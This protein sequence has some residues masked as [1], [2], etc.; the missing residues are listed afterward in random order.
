MTVS[1]ALARPTRKDTLKRSTRARPTLFGEGSRLAQGLGDEELN[2][3]VEDIVN[4]EATVC[5][6]GGGKAYERSGHFVLSA[7]LIAT[8]NIFRH[9]RIA[10]R[11]ELLK[12]TEIATERLQ[13][14]LRCK[15]GRPIALSLIKIPVVYCP[16]HIPRVQIASPAKHQDDLHNTYDTEM[17][18]EC[19]RTEITQRRR[20]SF[21]RVVV[22]QHLTESYDKKNTFIWVVVEHERA[23]LEIDSRNITFA[24]FRPRLGYVQVYDHDRDRSNDQ[25]QINVLSKALVQIPQPCSYRPPNRAHKLARFEISSVLLLA[26]NWD[27]ADGLHRKDG[28]NLQW[29]ARSR[30]PVDWNGVIGLVARA[31]C[32]VRRR[33]PSRS[34]GVGITCSLRTRNSSSSS[35]APWYGKREGE[36]NTITCGQLERKDHGRRLGREG[37]CVDTS[38]D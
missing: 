34:I 21:Q 13:T 29:S 7:H 17:K 2:L 27:P 1:L 20:E 14:R 15:R 10:K 19:G 6:G 31:H 12:H 30:A 35:V 32:K 38:A 22:G 18:L 36:A 25:D 24:S 3:S 9:T 26:T 11:A 5:R 23:Q 8:P 33:R 37:G 28:S 4:P 16:I